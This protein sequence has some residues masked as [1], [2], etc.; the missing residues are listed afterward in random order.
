MYWPITMRRL[1]GAHGP[2]YL[3]EHVTRGHEPIVVGHSSASALVADL[4]TKLPARGII[5]VDG[6]VPPSRGAAVPVRLAL[7]DFIKGLVEPDGML[8]IWSR[9]FARDTRRMSLVGLDILARDAAAFA[10]FESGLPRMHVGWFDDAIELATGSISL[11]VSSRLQRS[12]I[13]QPLRRNDAA[14]Q[15]RTC[16]ARICIRLASSGRDGK[17][18]FSRCRASTCF[19]READ[20]GGDDAEAAESGNGG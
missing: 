17:L 20:P 15:S 9:W 3:L 11:L 13:T 12:M 8:P 18:Q 7:H 10:R 16:T 2:R 5:I 1:P 19:R 14:G 4:A 6:D